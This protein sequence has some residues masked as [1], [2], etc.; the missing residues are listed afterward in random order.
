MLSVGHVIFMNM[1][2]IDKTNRVS[3]ADLC[4][5]ILPEIKLFHAI[6]VYQILGQLVI[7][8]VDLRRIN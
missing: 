6:T 3:V 5:L 1:Y 8:I 7:C 4:D 2:S